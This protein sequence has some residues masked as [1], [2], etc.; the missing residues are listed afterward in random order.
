MK[1]IYAWLPAFFWMGII[2][3]LSSRT[4][5]AVSETYILNF[6]FFKSLHVAE[7]ACLSLLICRGYRLSFPH[8]SLTKVLFLTFLTTFLYAVSDEV[9][10]TFVPTREGT[11]R[12]VLIDTIGITLSIGYT[13]IY[14]QHFKRIFLKI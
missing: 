3:Y 2:F 8:L 5:V 13:K 12:D 6:L 14:W 11:V 1:Y 4:R 9:H 7:Y 10:Q